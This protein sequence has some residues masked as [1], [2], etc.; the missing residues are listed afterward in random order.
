MNRAAA[1][2]AVFTDWRLI[3]GRKCVSICFEVP[4]ELADEAYRCLG[5]MPDP[6]SSVWCAIARLMPNMVGDGDTSGG[7]ALLASPP[8]HNE[9]GAGPPGG[10]AGARL[11]PR[12]EPAASHRFTVRA[13]MLCKDPLFHKFLEE[14]S[15]MKAVIEE[16]AAVFIRT[17]CG[18]KSRSEIKVGTAAATKLDF[19]ES[20]F[21]CWR[22]KTKYIEAA[23]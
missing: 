11:A 4:L 12:E 9:T 3:K 23:E 21:V 1:F 15:G 16:E 2:K 10:A 19:I 14:H 18:V 22:D 13:V 17:T 20:A 8:T 7:S 5:G 6:G